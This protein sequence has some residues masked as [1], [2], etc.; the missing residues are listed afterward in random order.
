MLELFP[1]RSRDTVENIETNG[2]LLL[3]AVSFK[4]EEPSKRDSSAE[5]PFRSS[6]EY[7]KANSQQY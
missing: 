7:S 1:L 5:A 3:L 6:H 4:E 2:I